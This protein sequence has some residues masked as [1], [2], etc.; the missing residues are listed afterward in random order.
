M[1][2]FFA[3]TFLF[4][5]PC[6]L[7]AQ[8]KMTKDTAQTTNDN[9]Q[10]DIIDVAR[11]IFKIK[12]REEKI[13]EQDEDKKVYF[14]FLP[15][16]SA[17]PA[18][19]RSL[20][21][22]TTA[23]T[24]FGPKSTTYISSVTFTPYTNFKG[25]YGLPIRSNIWLKDNAWN[26]QGDMRVLKYPQYTWGLGGSKGTNDKILLDYK[27]VRFYASAL[28]QIKPYFFAGVGYNLDYYINIQTDNADQ[29]RNFTGYKYGTESNKNSFS[30]GASI[31]L[32]YDSRSNSIN[33]LPGVF[34]NV[35]YR[36]NTPAM[37]SSNQWQSLYL[38][39]R[40]YISLNDSKQGP[41]E[42]L[43]IWAFYWTTLTKG[44][45]YLNLPSIG[46]DPYQRSG[47]GI[48]QN[49]Y[50]GRTL[51]YAESEYRRDITANGLLGFVV[52]ANVNTVSGSG[53][54]FSSW[55]PAGGTGLRIKFNK[56]SNTNIGID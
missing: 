21:T 17:T 16:S 9:G 33:P 25:R 44:T 15:I 40:R 5:F 37:G 54:L 31:N 4:L 28:K 48:D 30:S 42:V 45:P 24:Y 13:E 22:S 51:F 41:K 3:V 8:Q 27:Y 36:F 52:F 20:F 14:S 50:R 34:A 35:I 38:D 26:I 49:R 23:A 56:A 11:S 12:P 19:G 47:R 55:K 10:R 2:K 6:C 39:A 7:M 53:S 18:V 1:F 46:W 32:L 43:A 29:L